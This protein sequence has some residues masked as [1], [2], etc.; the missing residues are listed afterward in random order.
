[1]VF[2]A[3][4]ILSAIKM[5]FSNDDGAHPEKNVVIKFIRKIFPVSE[6]FEGQKFLT[7]IR[8]KLAL[9]PLA[10]VLIMVETTD[11]IFAVDSIPAIFAVTNNAYVVFT[12]NIFAILGLRSLYFVL[13]GAI[14][15]FRFLKTGLSI[16]L[17]FIGT[18]MLAHTKFSI[19]PT[20]SLYIVCSIIFVSIVASL[21]AALI[22]NRRA[23]SKDE[24]D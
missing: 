21:I 16:V 19:S 10:L 8:G 1:L 4:L 22:I 3:F 11:L 17:L 2:G 6:E 15:Y 14:G 13:A 9:T 5:I 7:R 20:A 24:E 23:I 18:K 12:S